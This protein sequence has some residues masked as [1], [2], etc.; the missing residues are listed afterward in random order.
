MRN[1]L[2]PGEDLQN[3]R[4]EGLV[5]RLLRLARTA[6]TIRRVQANG[7]RLPVPYLP[8]VQPVVDQPAI[9]LVLRHVLCKHLGIATRLGG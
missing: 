2:D 8:P 3:E 9:H 6:P 7:Q 4:P 1:A 5:L